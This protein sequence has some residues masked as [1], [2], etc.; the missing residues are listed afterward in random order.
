MRS[1][2]RMN[3]VPFADLRRHNLHQLLVQQQVIAETVGNEA[4]DP[5]ILEQERIRFLSSKG[6]EG[7][8]ALQDYLCKMG[9]KYEDLDWQIALPLRIRAHCIK[10]YKPKAEAHFL[11]R[12]NQLDKLY[13]AC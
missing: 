8:E 12:K 2:E 7:E 4:I 3:N 6:V 1:S 5:L 13:I 10:H 9:L 11:I